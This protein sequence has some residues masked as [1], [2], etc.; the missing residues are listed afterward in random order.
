MLAMFFSELNNLA[1]LAEFTIVPF[2]TEVDESK[3]Y[4]WKKGKRKVM[5][6]VLCGGTNFDAPTRYV[7]GKGFD[8]HIILTDLEAPKPI[9]SKCQRM[10]MT[11]VECKDRAYFQ[12]NER[13]IAID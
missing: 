11:S 5:E 6:R 4:V 1:K 12:T 9:P 8:G 3:V 10:W 13:V 7:N 2:D